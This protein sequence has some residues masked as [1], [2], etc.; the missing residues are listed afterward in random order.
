MGKKSIFKKRKLIRS[1][2]E[3]GEFYNNSFGKEEI[4]S[5]F[6]GRSFPA[7]IL[8]DED[9]N[10]ATNL[11]VLTKEDLIDLLAS[12]GSEER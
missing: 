1:H 3:Y 7:L 6:P 9:M 8:S 12:R 10:R 5:E 4:P 2:K 11:I